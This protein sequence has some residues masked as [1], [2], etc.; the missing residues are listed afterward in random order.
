MRRPLRVQ[1]PRGREGRLATVIPG[2]R[3]LA[4]GFV[5]G[6][7]EV[8]PTGTHLGAG[9][10]AGSMTPPTAHI[11]ASRSGQVITLTTAW[12]VEAGFSPP[13][14]TV[15]RDG[16]AV[17]TGDTDTP[18]YGT[19]TYTLIVRDRRGL[20]ATDSC[21]VTVPVPGT[22]NL[23]WTPIAAPP[24]FGSQLDLLSDGTEGGSFVVATSAEAP[25]TGAVRT[26]EVSGINAMAAHAITG[27][28]TGADPLRISPDHTRFMCGASGGYLVMYGK[29]GST[30]NLLDPTSPR[31]PYHV[32]RALN[33]TEFMATT[34]GTLLRTTYA[35]Q[36][37]VPPNVN[38]P[39]YPT[40]VF[41]DGS[42]NPWVGSDVLG[43][44]TI[45][46]VTPAGAWDS[47]SSGFGSRP[48]IVAGNMI[49]GRIA[50]N[51]G[52]VCKVFDGTSHAQ[53]AS[54]T[55][56]AGNY[57]VAVHPVYDLVFVRDAGFA[58]VR[59]YDF[60]GNQIGDINAPPS[61]P[62]GYIYGNQ[63]YLAFLGSVVFCSFKSNVLSVPTV[64]WA[65][66]LS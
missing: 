65:E 32:A 53:L 48:D 1:A 25:G 39:G 17:I 33:G 47:F 59:I 3:I 18:G 31:F 9:G 40:K 24:E 41:S 19:F 51:K 56:T 4:P 54:F 61:Q 30:W 13:T 15:L 55:I 57:V 60:A 11:S 16:A 42:I 6:D 38:N 26:Y 50:A 22:G 34:G 43:S 21:Q 10:A 7:V 23:F 29:S 35:T 28:I 27:L 62:G 64:A 37:Y 58:Y 20:T 36:D 66:L 63:V 52:T 44:D 46:A 14:L 12:T 49:G 8:G 2:G 45:F 5:G